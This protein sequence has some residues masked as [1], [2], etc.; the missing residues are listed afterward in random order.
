MLFEQP[1]IDGFLYRKNLFSRQRSCL[2]AGL[3]K[4]DLQAV[5]V[6]TVIWAIAASFPLASAMTMA[7]GG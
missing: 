1:V 7:S 4:I 6:F 3:R 2:G 5:R